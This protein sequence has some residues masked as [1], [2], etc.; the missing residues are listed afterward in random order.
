MQDPR[1]QARLDALRRQHELSDEAVDAVHAL[2]QEVLGTSTLASELEP[3]RSEEA[4]VGLG[5]RYVREGRIGRGGTGE[6]W[7]VQ[8]Q[9]LGRTLAMKVL[10]DA[11]RG[12]ALLEEAKAT[13]QLRHPAIVTVHDVGVLPDGRMYYTMEEVSGRTLL[14]ELLDRPPGPID[15]ALRRLLGAVATVAQGL[16]YAHDRGVL[17]R[18]VKPQNIMLGSYGE[19]RLLDFGVGVLGTPSYLAPEV[20]AGAPA[21]AASDQYALGATLFHVL[22]GRAPYEGSSDE[23]LAAVR[24]GPPALPE[25]HEALDPIL[26][27]ALAR[28]PHDR[29]PAC[30]DLARALLDFLTG[31]RAEERAHTLLAEA[32]A[33]TPQVKA[34]RDEA[35]GLR[36]RARQALRD[37]PLHAPAS[38]KEPWWAMEDRAAELEADAERQDLAVV[39]ALRLA[40]RE[41]PQLSDVHEALADYW[42]ARHQVLEAADDPGADAALSWLELHDRGRH[43]AWLRGFGAV[44]LRTEP[45]GARVCLY[46]VSRRDRRQQATFVRELGVTPLVEHPIEHGDYVLHV[47]AEGHTP[48]RVP[49]QIGRLEH[50]DAQGFGRP[51]PLAGALA[52]DDRYVPAG[53]A[54]FGSSD[55]TQRT[56]MNPRRIWLDG[57][58]MRRFPVTNREYLR[59]LDDLHDR[60]HVDEAR[61]R[62][63][64]QR[65]DKP[66]M[67]LGPDG[68]FALVPDAEGH[69]WDPDW[70]VFD[71]SWHDAVAYAAWMASRTGLPWRLPGELEWEKAARGVDG[72]RYPWGDDFEDTWCNMQSTR[73]RMEPR[74]VRSYPLDRGP[75]GVRGMAG[76]TSD[77][78]LDPF[79]G[80]GPPVDEQ[81][82]WTVP[83]TLPPDPEAR[84]AVRG[85]CWAFAAMAC[86]TAYRLALRP[87]ARRSSTSFR[88]AR[89]VGPT[90]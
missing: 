59:F 18:D 78:C 69:L 12:V 52:A 11:N 56:G 90:V 19:V 67:A 63:P 53:W 77:W 21:S 20:A 3:T 79:V 44:T 4:P 39:Q 43:A 31:V 87:S 38:D 66:A 16:A 68:R 88:L 49:V 62:A 28:A 61:E 73:P 50:V 36:A 27:R 47:L 60:G 5:E 42:Q 81:L 83:D 1:L 23:V 35:A 82:R 72:R 13:A 2:L 57:F 32:E 76:N 33:A 54:R 71:V 24:A 6:V 89:S 46:R 48:V 15:A 34:L 74:P 85:G 84:R 9:V 58:V 30:A 75:C 70:P 51:I 55:R 14:A 29:F 22:T 40:E 17:H 45:P 86:T 80:D 64:G 25:V 7:R 65:T 10:F 26:A 37:L 41:A 8:D